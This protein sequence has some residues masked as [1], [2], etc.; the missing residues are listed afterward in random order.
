M[1]NRRVGSMFEGQ[2]LKMLG[3]ES[4]GAIMDPGPTFLAQEKARLVAADPQGL[5]PDL[6]QTKAF[7]TFKPDGVY[8]NPSSLIWGRDYHFVEVKN[9]ADLSN[10]GNVSAMLSYLEAHPGSRLTL[11]TRD[12]RR[13][14]GPLRDRL[15][16][17]IDKGQVKVRVEVLM[18]EKHVISTP[19]QLP[20]WF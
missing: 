8:G 12:G 9:W 13:M 15:G 11:V 20:S 7:D 4:N 10:T 3:V 14:S 6:R 5:R 18:G 1:A 2:V 17:L 19:S 16:K